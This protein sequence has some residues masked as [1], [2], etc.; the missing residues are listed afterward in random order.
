MSEVMS[1]SEAIQS[2]IDPC[3]ICGKMVTASSVL[4][5][6]CDQW[7]HERCFKL[8]K[9][10]TSMARLFVCSKCEKA[11]N[12]SGEVQQKVIEVETMKRFFYLG[13]RLNASGGCAAAVSAK[14]KLG[15][16]KFRVW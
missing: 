7:I 12:G 11:T 2:R 15:W 4:C 13:D 8:K 1:E 5:T 16:K 9:V 3:R 6:K 14:T 10:T